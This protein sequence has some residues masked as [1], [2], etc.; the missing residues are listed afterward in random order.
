MTLLY[1][2]CFSGAGG[3][4]LLAAL[5]DAGLPFDELQA[6]L[7]RLGIG[8]YRL[9]AQRVTRHGL[10]GIY[11]Q[12]HTTDGERPARTLPAIE[13]IIGNSDLDGY[14]K[15]RSL[16]VFRRIARAEAAVHG[17]T[18][19]HIHFHEI[20]AVDSLV[21]I[22]GFAAGLA[23]MGVDQVYSS[24]LP[25]GGGTV[26]T[27]HGLLPAPAPA[28]LA[29]L[30]EV[31]APTVPGP[32]A[33]ELV[34]PTAA[35]LLAELATFRRP[36]MTLRAVG[37]GFG[38]KEFDWPN[39]VR[40]W[41][42]EALE[43]S[44][45]PVGSGEVVLLSCNLDDATGELLGHTLKRLFTAGALDAWFTPIQMKKNRPA[46][47]VSALARP[48]DAAA[49]AD[50]LLHETPTL[51]V[52]HQLVQRT[53]AAREMAEVETPWGIVRVKVKLLADQAVSASPEYDDCARVAEQAG[54]PL[55][56][57]MDAAWKG[58][59]RRNRIVS[60]P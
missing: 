19:D 5:L 29:L 32:A 47:L 33:T 8:G 27:E 38:T 7:S 48:E 30:A 37:Y 40:V 12:V 45:P 44:T 46:V 55:A 18:V 9:E 35:A 6:D 34:T 58:Y 42:G 14:V 31:G 3:D 16:S 60:R 15:E 28:T 53:V 49:L 39:A 20:G 36:P 23:R 54:V 41:L 56:D 1:V 11:L 59:A 25:L 4:M 2:D 57:V 43:Q 22:V 21:D 10:T 50:L 52:R 26:R 17:T 51:G 24:P 13:Q